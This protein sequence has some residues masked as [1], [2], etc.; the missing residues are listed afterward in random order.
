MNR[1][2]IVCFL[3]LVLLCIL[4]KSTLIVNAQ[5]YFTSGSLEGYAYAVLT[6]DGDLVFFRS[7][8]LYTAGTGKTVT[9]VMGYTYTGTLYCD[10]ECA[11][12]QFLTTKD[13]AK[14]KNGYVAPGQ[15]IKPSG[16]LTGWFYY[17]DS[18]IEIVN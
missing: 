2:R 6:D 7:T 5:E 9:D 8:E 12:N 18:L 11:T 15:T 13:R 16:S 10:V 14:V 17:C 4:A 1:R 3:L